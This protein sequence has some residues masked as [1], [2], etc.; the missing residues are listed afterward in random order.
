MD[1]EWGMSSFFRYTF[2]NNF[3]NNL[4]ACGEM[5]WC[6]YL[7]FELSKAF[8]LF[9]INDFHLSNLFSGKRE[10]NFFFRKTFLH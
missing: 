2:K 3:V 8:V 9:K 7:Y 5:F 10:L 6:C 4:S 1:V